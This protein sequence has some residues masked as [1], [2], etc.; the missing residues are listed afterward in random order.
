MHLLRVLVTELRLNLHEPNKKSIKY[1]FLMRWSPSYNWGSNN[2]V[3]GELISV[4][5]PDTKNSQ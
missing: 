4:I 3:K 2:N 5:D 1:N